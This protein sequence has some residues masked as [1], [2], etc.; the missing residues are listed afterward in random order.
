[1]LEDLRANSWSLRPCC[2]V[3]AYRVA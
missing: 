1:M 2:M 3:L